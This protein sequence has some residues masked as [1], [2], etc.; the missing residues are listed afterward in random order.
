MEE[1]AAQTHMD[2]LCSVAL[3]RT[4]ITCILAMAL[5]YLVNQAYPG[6]QAGAAGSWLTFIG[7]VIGAFQ[8]KKRPAGIKMTL[9]DVR[10][11]MKR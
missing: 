5:G 8:F 9:K 6:T 3:V 11:A 1:D 2:R 4:A 7:M 10:E